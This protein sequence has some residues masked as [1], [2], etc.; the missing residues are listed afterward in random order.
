MISLLGHVA[1]LGRL[2]SAQSTKLGVTSSLTLTLLRSLSVP[3]FS[4]CRCEPL[5]WLPLVGQGLTLTWE[6]VSESVP[7]AVQKA[8]L[9]ERHWKNTSAARAAPRSPSISSRPRSLLM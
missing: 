4:L 9:F 8:W 5:G 7:K 6:Q 2:G 1:P 3:A